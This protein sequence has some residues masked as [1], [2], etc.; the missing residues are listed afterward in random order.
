MLMLLMTTTTTMTTDH[1]RMSPSAASCRKI[2]EKM[3]HEKNLPGGMA[4]GGESA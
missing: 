3:L 1:K 4:W 2:N